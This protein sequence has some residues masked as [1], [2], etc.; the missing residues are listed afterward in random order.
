[1]SANVLIPGVSEI[2]MAFEITLPVNLYAQVRDCDIDVRHTVILAGHTLRDSAS[3]FNVHGTTTIVCD[4]LEIVADTMTLDGKI[5]FEAEQVTAPPRLDLRP[6]NG[7]QV[8]WAGQFAD[9]Y[10]WNRF[11]TTLGPPY[12]VPGEDALT[13]LVDECRARLPGHGG[14]LTLNTD[15]SVPDD[16]RR[17]RWIARRFPDAFPRLIALM[18]EHTLASTDTMDAS[19]NR[20]KTRVRFRV[21]WDDLRD[22]LRDPASGPSLQ[23]FIREARRAFSG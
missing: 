5:W 19:G 3:I 16:D 10:P 12:T 20:P 6:K 1:M 21:T 15:F 11:S 18:V 2:E 13:D 17:A 22:A 4:S 8:G 9:Q 7:A 14:V 23:E